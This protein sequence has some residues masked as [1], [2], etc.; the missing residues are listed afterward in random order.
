MSVCTRPATHGPDADP[1][2][3]ANSIAAFAGA[4]ECEHHPIHTVLTQATAPAI[5]IYCRLR[6]RGAPSCR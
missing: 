1:L 3:N 5:T 4:G 6:M 2:A